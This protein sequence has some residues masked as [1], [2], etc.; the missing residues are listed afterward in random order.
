MKPGISIIIPVFNGEQYIAETLDSICRQSFGDFEVL[1][2]DDGSTD[3]TLEIVTKYM[4][5][6]EKR[7]HYFHKQ[8]GGV[9]SARNVGIQK[10]MGEYVIFLDSDDTVENDFLEVMYKELEIGGKDWVCCVYQVEGKVYEGLLTYQMG[11]NLLY[12]VLSGNPL[13][14]TACWTIRKSALLESGILFEETISFT[15]DYNFFCKWLYYAQSMGKRGTYLPIPLVNYRLRLD[16]LCQRGRPWLDMVHIRQD[17]E[18]TKD[19]YRYI[20]KCAYGDITLYID[21]ILKRLKRK[22]LYNLWCLLLL[23]S[24]ND[25]K[26]LRKFYEEDK[27]AY[28]LHTVKLELK[29]KVWEIIIHPGICYVAWFLKPYKRFKKYRKDHSIKK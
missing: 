4:E 15:E 11:N 18:S 9:S 7:I 27:Q 29:Y 13:P 16:S 23:G 3:S 12:H 6:D 2:I 26:C 28:L 14:Q 8:N 20:K 5:R 22:Y 17:V 24:M 10:A 19:I 1:V 25:F 21:A